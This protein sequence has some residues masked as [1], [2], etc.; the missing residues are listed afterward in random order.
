MSYLL[1]TNIFIRCKNELPMDIFQGFWKWLADL[2][3]AGQIFS[4]IKVKEEIDRGRCLS[5]GYSSS[6]WN[7]SGYF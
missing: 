4:S 7:E 1:D 5:G 6:S 2:A 3:R